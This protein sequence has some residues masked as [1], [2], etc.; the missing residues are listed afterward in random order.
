[1]ILYHFLSLDCYTFCELFLRAPALELVALS[2]GFQSP[3][4][5]VERKAGKVEKAYKMRKQSKY[6]N[7]RDSS[8][9]NNR[10]SQAPQKKE[11]VLSPNADLL[12]KEMG[13]VL[14][15]RISLILRLGVTF[16]APGG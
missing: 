7:T 2:L 4:K 11:C 9:K 12:T 1:M 14:C 16:V 8:W 10:N 5:Q 13:D 15:K 6:N 3:E